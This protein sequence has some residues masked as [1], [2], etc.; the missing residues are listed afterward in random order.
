MRILVLSDSHG[1]FRS[2]LNAVRAQPD[3]DAVIFLGDGFKDFFAVEKLLEGKRLYAVCGNN[4]FYC[5]YPKK[6]IIT[7]GG[8]NIYITHGH[9]E[10]V[11]SGLSALMGKARENDCTLVLYGHTHRQQSDYV[12]G[13]YL[14]NPGSLLHN[15]YG[16]VDITEKGIICIGMKLKG[17]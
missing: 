1:N 9:Y 12:D 2:I 13:T 17:I 11:K 14:F 6:R 8:I 16:V 15:E 5:D 10:Y 7:E 4:D 3:A